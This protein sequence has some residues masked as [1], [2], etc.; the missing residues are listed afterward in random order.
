MSSETSVSAGVVKIGVGGSS[1]ALLI[2]SLRDSAGGAWQCLNCAGGVVEKNSSAEEY[3]CR[4]IRARKR[5]SVPCSQQLKGE[6]SAAIILRKLEITTR[7]DRSHRVEGMTPKS[8]VRPEQ[9][10]ERAMFFDGLSAY[11]EQV[12]MKRQ[13]GG[14]SGETAAL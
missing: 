1:V 2:G 4:I 10:S 6:Y 9:R 12:G 11:S 13:E 3:D 8:R 14:S 5:R 7:R